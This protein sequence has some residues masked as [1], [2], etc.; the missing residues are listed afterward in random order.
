[1][2]EYISALFSRLKRRKA[3]AN[4][5]MCRTQKLQIADRAPSRLIVSQLVKRNKL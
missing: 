4:P 2:E 5:V 3:R 1:M